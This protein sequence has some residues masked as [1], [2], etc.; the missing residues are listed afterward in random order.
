MS[1]RNSEFTELR[2]PF[3]KPK[4]ASEEGRGITV[5]MA[6]NAKRQQQRAAASVLQTS[7]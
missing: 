2:R 6:R 4:M 1:E 7:E 3:R 5:V